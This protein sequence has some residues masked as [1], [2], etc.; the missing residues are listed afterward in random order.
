MTSQSPE[1]IL[2][3]QQAIPLARS[4]GMRIFGG[5]VR[6]NPIAAILGVVWLVISFYPVLYM[7][8]TSLKSQNG[9]LSGS[10]W[11]PPKHPTLASYKDV[12]NNDFWRY[13][14]NSVIV[15]VVS[16]AL[17]ASCSLMAAYVIARIKSKFVMGAFNIFLIGLA[18]PLQATIIPIYAL[19]INL[20]LYDKLIALI[21][22]AVAFGIPLAVLIL[23]N[24]IRDIPRE[25]YESMALEGSSHLRV[26][27]SLVLPLA[28]PALITVMVYNTL[29]TWNAF[30]FPLILTQSQ[31]ERVL[32]L[33]LWSFQGQFGINVPALLAAVIL[34]AAPIILLYIV[35][36]RQLLSGLTAGFGR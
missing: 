2:P 20:H 21:L 6:G 14:L 26:L 15:T 34:S 8:F 29:L 19:M 33:A 28:R 32:P 23:V 25:L 11:L 1:K 13:F 35:G 4:R 18:V 3:A 9:Y 27:F 16:V 5:R 22:P 17:I 24:F 12:L 36:R 7:V 31:N 10:P 30:L